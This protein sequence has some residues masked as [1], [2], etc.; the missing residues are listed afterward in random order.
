M[1]IILLQDNWEWKELQVD[2]D[3][4]PPRRDLAAMIHIGGDIILLFGGRS[5]TGK[6]LNDLW[7]FD[8]ERLVSRNPSFLC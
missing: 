4:R 1:T 3:C 7:L 5:D 2:E 8:I 6:A